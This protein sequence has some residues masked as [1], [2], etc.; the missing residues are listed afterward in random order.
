MKL[1]K[2][3][4]LSAFEDKN[5]RRGCWPEGEHLKGCV[6]PPAAILWADGDRW[7]P[8]YEDIMAED[9]EVVE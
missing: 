9:W 6:R 5:I 3:I 2:A 1:R 8:S 4:R 7:E